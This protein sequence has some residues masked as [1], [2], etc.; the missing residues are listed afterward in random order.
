MRGVKLVRLSK[1]SKNNIILLI[2]ILILLFVSIM[3]IYIAGDSLKINSNWE[4]ILGWS[5]LGLVV[6]QALSLHLVKIK[7]TEIQFFLLLFFYL[8]MFGQIILKGVLGVDAI[9]STG[10]IQTLMDSRYSD[11]NMIQSAVFI[12]CCIQGIVCGFLVNPRPMPRMTF[13]SSSNVLFYTGIGILLL[14]VPC[15]LVYCLRMIKT[16]QYSASYEALIS[17]VGLVDDFANF[18][19]PGFLCLIFSGKITKNKMNILLLVLLGYYAIVMICTG[20]RRYQVV[21]VMVLFLA[22][23]RKNEIKF[24]FKY[25]PL[26]IIGIWGLNL[27]KILRNIRYGGLVSVSDF[28]IKYAADIFSLSGGVVEQT[29]YEFGGSFYTVCLGLKFVPEIISHRFGT[30][31]ISGI[32][33]ILPLGFLYNSSNIFKYGRIAQDLMDLGKTTVG[34]SVIQDFYTNFGWCGGIIAA[35]V[36]GIIINKLFSPNKMNLQ[37]GI[38]WVKYYTLFYALIHLPRA[39]FTEVIRTAV[40][41]VTILYVVRAI[42]KYICQDKYEK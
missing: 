24:S 35:V 6:I 40:W 2:N 10:H 9:E 4:K 23:I 26:M 3:G 20:D 41:G 34:A 36:C 37:D 5:A 15:Q 42:V 11:E 7:F 31:I 32:I 19:I 8:F 21:S 28:F 14:A 17:S 27:L 39:S 29:L 25:I 1:R 33:S 30:T 12:L 18:T 16:A 22:Y 38:Y 13:V